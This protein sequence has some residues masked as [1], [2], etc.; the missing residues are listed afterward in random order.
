MTIRHTTVRQRSKKIESAFV[1]FVRVHHKHFMSIRSRPLSSSP[2]SLSYTCSPLFDADRDVTRAKRFIC[3]CRS[4]FHRDVIRLL[5]IYLRRQCSPVTQNNRLTFFLSIGAEK[6][7]MNVSAMD[8][9][10]IVKIFLSHCSGSFSDLPLNYFGLYDLNIRCSSLDP[11][12]PE[13]IIIV[14]FRLK[15]ITQ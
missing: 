3:H 4:S 12:Q 13:I 8:S 9:R 1:Q 15:C 6:T 7:A 2:S 11:N 10:V 5:R 14:M